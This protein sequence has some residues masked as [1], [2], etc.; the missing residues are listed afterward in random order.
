MPI[1]KIP[2]IIPQENIYIPAD[3][4]FRKGYNDLLLLGNNKTFNK[5]AKLFKNIFLYK[6][7]DIGFH[8]ESLLRHHIEAINL[9]VERFNL[10]LSLNRDKP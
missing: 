9:N 7:L 3:G 10:N 8:P 2:L 1:Q 6:N 4:D 5:Y